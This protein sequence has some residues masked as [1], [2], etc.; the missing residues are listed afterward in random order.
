MDSSP[1]LA[2]VDLGKR[3]WGFANRIAKEVVAGAI[4]SKKNSPESTKTREAR[5]GSRPMDRPL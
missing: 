3:G 2:M 4:R 5:V 1:E